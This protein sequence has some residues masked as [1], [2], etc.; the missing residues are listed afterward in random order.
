MQH[1]EVSAL[2]GGVGDRDAASA[3]TVDRG[4]TARWTLTAIWL[5]NRDLAAQS[6]RRRYGL[7]AGITDTDVT[8]RQGIDPIGRARSDIHL[9][10]V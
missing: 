2:T 5:P 10:G 8:H 9:T 6:G 3:R 4:C 7:A 1:A